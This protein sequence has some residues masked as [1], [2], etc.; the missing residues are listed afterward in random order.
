[1]LHKGVC[2]I[3]ND[4]CDVT[5]L[6]IDNKTIFLICQSFRYQETKICDKPWNTKT[7]FIEAPADYLSLLLCQS[8]CEFI[9]ILNRNWLPC[10]TS[11]GHRE[12]SEN[13]WLSKEWEGHDSMENRSFRPVGIA[14]SEWYSRRCCLLRCKP[15]DAQVICWERSPGCKTVHSH[16]SRGRDGSVSVRDRFTPSVE[17][18]ILSQPID[19]EMLAHRSKVGKREPVISEVE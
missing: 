18:K 1:M 16:L 17:F 10:I 15:F 11:R 6:Q 14:E 4:L 5:E 7:D 12:K 8:I 9:L 2:W 19:G 3:N 13:A